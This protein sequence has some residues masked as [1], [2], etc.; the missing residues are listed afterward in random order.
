[1]T[2]PCEFE[3]P[4]P[5][6]A[7]YLDRALRDTCKRFPFL[8]RETIGQSL[9]G[10]PIWGIS[11]GSMHAPF[12]I[13]AAFHG[14]EWITGLIT[15]HFLR[16]FCY[17]ME[18]DQAFYGICVRD[19]LHQYGIFLVPCVNPD[20][21]EI[22]IHGSACA[23]PFAALVEQAAKGDTVHWQANAR[24][25]D[26]NHNFHAGWFRLR[27]MEQEA[28]ICGPSPTR[29]GG[30]YPESEP[31]TACLATLCRRQNFLRA[32]ALH[33]Q[34]WEIYFRYGRHTPCQSRKIAERMANASKSVVS[35]PQ[36]LAS[37]GGFK[38]WFID[39]FHRPGFTLELGEGT[40]PLPLSDLDAIYAR[41]EPMLAEFLKV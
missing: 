34:G 12:L 29:F 4:G 7:S 30:C 22:Q 8:R 37:L 5:M 17:A 40:N 20:G 39:F 2:I 19:F 35:D 27:R 36:G 14:M 32:A 28:G 25:V 23:G 1:M 41:T 11:A 18:E 16:C 6:D 24:G 38:D 21:V 26:L 31:E 13:T 33:T 10:R 15:I 9:V 3:P